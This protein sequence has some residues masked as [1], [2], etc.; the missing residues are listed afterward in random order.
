M[1]SDLTND[2]EMLKQVQ[3]LMKCS[4]TRRTANE[5]LS[6]I[7]Y[8]KTDEVQRTEQGMEALRIAMEIT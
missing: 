7:I 4:T 6:T 2:I 5:I 3:V 8:E 1:I